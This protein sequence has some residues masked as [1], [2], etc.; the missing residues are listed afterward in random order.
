MATMCM[1]PVSTSLFLSSSHQLQAFHPGVSEL[2]H[3][4]AQ[5]ADAH[6]HQQRLQ[7]VPQRVQAAHDEGQQDHA[8][9]PDDQVPGHAGGPDRQPGQRAVRAHLAQRRAGRRSLQRRLLR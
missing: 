3:Q 8:V 4:A 7:E 9:R 2:Q 5:R 1:N 6:P